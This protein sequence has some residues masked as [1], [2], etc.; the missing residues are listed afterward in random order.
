MHNGATWFVSSVGSPLFTHQHAYAR[1]FSWRLT[2]PVCHFYSCYLTRNSLCQRLLLTLGCWNQAA[3]ATGNPQCHVT[4]SSSTHRSHPHRQP[5]TQP[6]WVDLSSEK[7]LN[8]H[9]LTNN[10]LYYSCIVKQIPKKYFCHL[11]FINKSIAKCMVLT[12]VTLYSQ[13]K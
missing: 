7:W 3:A 9:L 6:R 8:F 11:F 5:Q 13:T 10:N 2:W 4:P 1:A 12:L